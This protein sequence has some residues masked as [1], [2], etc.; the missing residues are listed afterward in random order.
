M[1][2]TRFSRIF[3][4]GFVVFL[5]AADQAALSQVRD[6]RR[7]VRAAPDTPGLDR[8]Q[9]TEEA[10]R[11]AGL[12][13]IPK[14]SQ[15]LRSLAEVEGTLHVFVYLRDQPLRGVYNRVASGF[16]VRLAEAEDRLQSLRDGGKATRP[17][18]SA[19]RTDV[20]AALIEMRQEVAAQVGLLIEPQQD[21]I[22]SLLA[23]LGAQRIRRFSLLNM[24]S[25]QI[26][27][28]SLPALEADDRI[29]EIAL[30][31][32]QT[33]ELEVSVPSLGAP[34]FWD[35]G[36]FGEGETVAVLDS[37]VNGLHPAFAGRVR[38][39]V[40]LDSASGC[41]P[42]DI[43]SPQDLGGHGTHV[44]GIIAS[45][46]T[47]QSPN[48]LGVA[49][50]ISTLWNF[51]ISCFN[52]SSFPDVLLLAVEEA[53]RF[54][55]V[56]I[57][58]SSNGGPANQEDNL[59]SRMID[60]F[61]DMYDLT[62]VKSAGNR[63]PA[64]RTVTSPGQAFNV[65]T[66]ANID[67]K[68]T[69]TRADDS[70]AQNSS[71]GPTIGGRFKPD[72]AA[73]G[74]PIYSTDL[75]SGFRLDSGTSFAAPHIAGAAALLRQAGVFDRLA[76]KALLINTT[77]LAGWDPDY[78]WGYADLRLAF[79]QKDRVIA[80]IA[81]EEQLTPEPGAFQL[82]RGTL[83]G[84][85]VL[86]ATATW[87][88]F[89][90]SG[91]SFLR[92]VDLVLYQGPELS[93]FSN[94]ERNNVEQ[95]IFENLSEQGVEVVLKVK[96][97]NDGFG[98]SEPYALALSHPGFAV[99]DGPELQQ[100]CSGPESVEPGED[101]TIDC[102]ISNRGDLPAFDIFED[103][104]FQAPPTLRGEIR[105]EGER[106]YQGRLDLQPGEIIDGTLT[107][108][109]PN[110]AGRH[111]LSVTA[112]TESYGE[113]FESNEATLTIN[114]G[115]P[116]VVPSPFLNPGSPQPISGLGLVE[117]PTLFSGPSGFRLAR[118]AKRPGAR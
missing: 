113:T 82:V 104:E 94:S 53:L 57:I 1:K 91:A 107:L 64:P 78:G 21:E 36:I 77:D 34:A 80:K 50:G 74:Q 33:A 73:P 116:V 111:V 41:P 66:V 6:A 19:A 88:R 114:V 70:I 81:E 117:G 30:V 39:R 63:G 105:V 22:E 79:E 85:Q 16:D 68:G 18:L 89:V 69:P 59:Q 87:N 44:A 108:T 101:F 106:K 112:S 23:V 2:T 97:Q 72:L 56:T 51:K 24:L 109:A 11:N 71:R 31:G 45:Q 26:P 76:I 35:A 37:G 61:V 8:A 100:Q 110:V 52:G 5:A 99:A 3:L 38:S 96:A 32:E 48:R 12:T 14:V 103:S 46:G 55:P 84:G 47:L 15:E 43:Q 25:A 17:Q 86:S 20:D 65:I 49:W 10:A 102:T 7:K 28:E 98:I 54:T 4:L 115:A 60:M 13:L 93:E 95:I 40:F 118:S 62:F 42:L 83:P 90:R 27:S 9:L 58:N 75:A 92:N 67:T 29:G